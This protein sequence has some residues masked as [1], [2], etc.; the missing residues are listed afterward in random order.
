M[1][2]HSLTSD[3]QSRVDILIYLGGIIAIAL[4]AIAVLLYLIL[5]FAYM[6]YRERNK[7]LKER[8]CVCGRSKEEKN[9]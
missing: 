5:G 8:V 7:I 1:F 2:N 6:L 3:V 9:Q 4:F